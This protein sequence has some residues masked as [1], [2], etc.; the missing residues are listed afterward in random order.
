MTA[1]VRAIIAED[2]PLQRKLLRTMLADEPDISVVAE[3]G[4]GASA[5][6]AIREHRPD[7]VFLDVQMP[8]LD[9]FE[10]VGSVGLHRMPVTIFVTAFDQYALRAFE[11]HALDYLLKPFDSERLS[12]AVR[13]AVQQ[14]R[15]ATNANADDRLTSLLREI[16]TRRSAPAR[17]ALRTDG[18]VVFVETSV[19]DYIEAAGKLVRVHAG[20]DRYEVRDTLTSVASQLDVADFVRV[21]RSTIVNVSRIKEI[22]PW[23]QGDYVLILKTGTRV[24]SG[25]EYR[26]NI[27]ALMRGK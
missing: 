21:H 10:I 11:V 1:P 17:L 4:D 19:I 8:E 26:G 24:T 5:V 27:Q 14:V 18:R 6:Q 15:Q 22:Q 20:S 9:A 13:R 12:H 23:F 25:R 2:E 16:G 3:A 7:L